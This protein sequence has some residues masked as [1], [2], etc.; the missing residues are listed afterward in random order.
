MLYI[1]V[2]LFTFKGGYKSRFVL[3]GTNHRH[4]S[5]GVTRPIVLHNDYPGLFTS[6]LLAATGLTLWL[7][8]YRALWLV[9]VG[10]MSGVIYTMVGTAGVIINTMSLYALLL[11]L[12]QYYGVTSTIPYVYT[13]AGTIMF[14]QWLLL[15]TSN[16]CS[17]NTVVS[18]LST[19]MTPAIAPESILVQPH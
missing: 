13:A 8:F 6:L 16:N 15:C 14:G 1:L 3:T 19:I 2:T 17:A 18:I 10:T 9:H 4:K 12:C 5:P 11:V 7:A